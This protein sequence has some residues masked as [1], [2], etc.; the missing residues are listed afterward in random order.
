MRDR[1]I[2]LAVAVS[3]FLLS[4]ALMGI[5]LYGLP[6]LLI[7]GLWG[8][9]SAVALLSSSIFAR[10]SALIW[11][12]VYVGLV[13]VFSIIGLVTDKHVDKVLQLWAVVDLVAIF[14]L[15]KMLG[16]A[17]GRKSET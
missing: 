10:K 7:F 3:Q 11:H 13:L 6:L 14:Y 5:A 4:L 8:L 1:V 12:L 16:Y 2:I 9:V 17:L 15:A